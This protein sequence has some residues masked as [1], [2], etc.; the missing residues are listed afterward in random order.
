MHVP[1]PFSYNSQIKC[2]RT[3]VNMG[4]FSCL[5][6]GIRAERLFAPLSGTLYKHLPLRESFQN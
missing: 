4:I 6:C 5:V 1:H 2:S 3:H